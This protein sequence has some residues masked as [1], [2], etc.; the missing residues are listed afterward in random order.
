LLRADIGRDEYAVGD[1]FRALWHK[2]YSSLTPSSLRQASQALIRS[3]AP[4]ARTPNLEPVTKLR[5][6]KERL[7][8]FA[9]DLLTDALVLELT[10]VVIGRSY[11]ITRQTAKRYAID[12]LGALAAWT[13]GKTSSH[14][15]RPARARRGSAVVEKIDQTPEKPLGR[16]AV[17]AT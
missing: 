15:R 11:R 16:V 6:I 13:A 12:A 4:G 2:A 9:F 1:H 17:R 3:S 14:T 10:W 7:G 8:N 5:K